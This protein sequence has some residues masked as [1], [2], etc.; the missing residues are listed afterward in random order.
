MYLK[1]VN[2][3]QLDLLKQMNK[4][5]GKKKLP[6]EAFRII[7]KVLNKES[8][9]THD[10]IAVFMK[11]VKNDTLG[12]YDEIRLYPYTIKEDKGLFYNVKE[13]RNPKVAWS[14]YVIRLKETGARIYLVY[15]MK[16]KDIRKESR[17]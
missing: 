8:L 2:E 1:I 14:C 4:C 11:P 13:K 7:R 15:S 17:L 9:G 6:K 16:N 12:L 10:Y 3:S 5:L